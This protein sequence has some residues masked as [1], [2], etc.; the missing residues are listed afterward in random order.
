[1]DAAGPRRYLVRGVWPAG[2]YGVHAAEMKAQKTWNAL[3][4]A[5]SVASG[6]SWLG[7][8]PIDDPGPV[9]VFAGEG[10]EAAIVRRLRAI[11]ASRGL[12]AETLPIVV[13]SRAPHLSDV[14]HLG[15]VAEQLTATRPR[16]VIL[17]PLYLAARGASGSDLYAMGAVLERVQHFM[18]NP[19]PGRSSEPRT[20]TVSTTA[21]SPT[22]TATA[23]VLVKS[24]IARPVTGTGIPA[25]ATVTAVPTAT[26]ATLS[27][28]ATATGTTTVTIGAASPAAM[29]FIGWS[30]ET[31]AEA[32]AHTLAAV[33]AGSSP[34][35][36][37][38][39]RAR[40]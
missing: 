18:A 13:C 22:V 34:S 33:N 25:G 3:D 19:N 37:P 23:G 20:V 32:G 6:T 16:L 14:E 26:G 21:G 11:C 27:A 38:G 31:D 36:Q 39:Q 9:L 5:V 29:G 7:A 28:N 4:L 35:V 30:P 40:G 8:F 1:V 17:D 15:L 10:G 2:S 12:T 24:D